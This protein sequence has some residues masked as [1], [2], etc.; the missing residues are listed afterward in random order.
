[1]NWCLLNLLD[2]FSVVG[3]FRDRV[4][5]AA[6]SIY[7]NYCPLVFKR[8]VDWGFFDDHLVL[9][10]YFTGEGLFDLS[11]NL[12]WKALVHCD[13]LLFLLSLSFILAVPIRALLIFSFVR[14]ALTTHRPDLK[15]DAAP[16][17]CLAL[18]IGVSFS[19]YWLSGVFFT[20]S[21]YD[22][23]NIAKLFAISFHALF[24][25]AL[26]H[27]EVFLWDSRIAPYTCISI[28][29]TLLVFFQDVD[30]LRFVMLSWRICLHFQS[31]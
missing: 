9:G 12:R 4:C 22:K 18:F 13:R 3:W 29:P 21:F 28:V 14:N 5:R 19:A 1:M 2:L 26:R 31:F 17:V 27:S 7:L 20:P 24:A 25:I 10:H 23:V 11:L 8:A 16:L 15:L 6:A 30:S